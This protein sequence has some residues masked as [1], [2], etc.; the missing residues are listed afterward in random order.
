ML[1]CQVN[2]GET[3]KRSLPVDEVAKDKSMK[4]RSKGKWLKLLMVISLGGGLAIGARR[5]LSR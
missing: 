3:I 5:V 1:D 2:N 4:K